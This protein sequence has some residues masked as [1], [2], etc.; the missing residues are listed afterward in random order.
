ML[1]KFPSI[2]L[3]A[4]IIHFWPLPKYVLNEVAESYIKAEAEED[5][6]FVSLLKSFITECYEECEK[7][8]EAQKI[9]NQDVNFVT[10]RHIQDLVKL[11]LM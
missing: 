7:F 11:V 10:A 4:T 8:F 6:N 1:K 9:M 2:F 3:D 5:E